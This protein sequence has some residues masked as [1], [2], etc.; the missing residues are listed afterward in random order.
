MIDEGN[1]ARPSL[2]DLYKKLRI[3]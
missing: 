1:I 2:C 3:W